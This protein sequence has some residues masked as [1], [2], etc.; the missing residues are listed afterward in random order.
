MNFSIGKLLSTAKNHL[1]AIMTGNFPVIDPIEREY[2]SPYTKNIVIQV[3]SV[4]QRSYQIPDMDFFRDKIIVGIHTRR[5]SPDDDKLSK[6]GRKLIT[7]AAMG[8]CF[9]KLTQNNNLVDEQLPLEW[10]IHETNAMAATYGQKILEGGFT[11][12]SSGIEFS[13]TIPAGDIGRD[14]ELIFHYV[15]ISQNCYQ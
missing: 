13:G 7:N 14:V 12:Q 10:L 6:N 11:T 15:P 5:Q 2:S 3:T 4:T 1:G 9:V 8:Q